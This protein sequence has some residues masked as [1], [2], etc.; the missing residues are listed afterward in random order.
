MAKLAEEQRDEIVRLYESGLS[1]GNIAPRFGVS[2]Q[3]VHEVVRART[4]TRPNMPETP[5]ERSALARLGAAARWARGSDA[6]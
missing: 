6:A 5:E 3:A 4:T 1:C 2:R